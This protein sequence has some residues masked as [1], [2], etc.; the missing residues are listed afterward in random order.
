MI[1]TPLIPA[2]A[3]TQVFYLTAQCFQQKRLGPRFRGDERY[4]YLLRTSC[5]Q[6][7]IPNASARIWMAL[8][9]WA[10]GF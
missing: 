2:K 7:A 10:A 5:Q 3:G 4:I 8:G 9:L 6:L 1:F